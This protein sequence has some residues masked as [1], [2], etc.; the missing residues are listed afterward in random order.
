VLVK[1]HE[2]W[3]RVDS[4]REV[5]GVKRRVEEATSSEVFDDTLGVGK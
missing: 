5:S 2:I 1:P 3:D 4:G